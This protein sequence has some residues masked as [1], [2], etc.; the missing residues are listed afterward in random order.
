MLISCVP[1]LTVSK[2]FKPA[3]L[4]HERAGP[5]LA[6]AQCG[7][8]CSC[9]VDTLGTSGIMNFLLGA[10]LLDYT[11]LDRFPPF[12]RR[13]PETRSVQVLR[14]FELVRGNPTPTAWRPELAGQ[15]FPLSSLVHELQRLT[16]VHGNINF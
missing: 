3:D 7:G 4:D 9:L 12:T 1:G 6:L 2:R 14:T 10:G 15:L 8:L 13:C 11:L 5:L 16:F